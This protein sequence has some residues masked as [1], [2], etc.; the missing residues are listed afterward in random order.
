MFRFLIEKYDV[1]MKCYEK[2]TFYIYL[3]IYIH[4][5]NIFYYI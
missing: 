3:Y 4:R 5:K 1:Y 2:R